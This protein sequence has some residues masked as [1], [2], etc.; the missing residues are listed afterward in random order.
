MRSASRAALRTLRPRVHAAVSRFGSRETRVGFASELYSVATLL[1]GQPRLRR[2]L[3]D[4]ASS[5]DARAGLA[6]RLIDDKVSAST[7]ALVKDAVSLRWSAPWDM[8]DAIEWAGDDVLL[9]AAEQDDVIEDVEDELFR[10]E[11]IL[12]NESDLTALLDEQAVPAD[13]RRELLDGVVGQKVHPI[14]LALLQ[15][16]VASQRKRS[17]LLAIDDLIEAAAQRRERS[18]ARAVSATEL[19]SEQQEH[20][21]RALSRIYDRPIEVH[22]A[23]DPSVRGGLVVRVGDEVIDGSVAARLTQLRSAF[24]G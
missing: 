15:H 13:R 19:S 5:P 21:A 22:Y 17:L 10:F 9:A 20:L 16:A 1:T 18:L 24:A 2:M 6:A 4:P 12:D 14:T 7:V 3:G 8:L 11:R 23:I